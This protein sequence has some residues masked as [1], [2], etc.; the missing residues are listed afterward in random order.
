MTVQQQLR[1]TGVALVTPFA[2]DGSI[3]FASLGKVID[4][5]IK[6]GVEYLITLGTTGETPTLTKEEKIEIINFTFSSSFQFRMNFL[7]YFL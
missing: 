2:K 1:G 6:G 5:V 7:S 4:H 3:D